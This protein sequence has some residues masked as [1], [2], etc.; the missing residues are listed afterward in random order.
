MKTW[1]KSGLIGAGIVILARILLAISLKF[2]YEQT[3]RIIPG[4]DDLNLLMVGVA[5]LIGFII[6]AAIDWVFRKIR[7]INTNDST[8]AREN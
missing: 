2:S 4:G 8:N 3:L 5:I 1:I 6:G 7:S